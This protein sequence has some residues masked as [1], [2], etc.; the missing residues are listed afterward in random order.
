MKSVTTTVRPPFTCSG[1]KTTLG[2]RIAALLPAHR[3]Y[4]E[5]Y[6]GSPAVLLA[7]PRAQF[8]TVDDLDEGPVTFWRVPRDRGDELETVCALTPHSRAGHAAASDLDVIDELDRARRVWARL[9]QGRGGMLRRTGWRSYRD[10]ARRTGSVPWTL[11]A[12]VDWLQDAT[13]RLAV[14]QAQRHRTEVLGSNR[15]L[16]NHDLSSAAAGMP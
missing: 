3:H 15:R 6:A 14:G 13:E 8:E 2:R 7:K 1:G 5:P 16:G 11:T 9:G 12:Y 4:T 10:A